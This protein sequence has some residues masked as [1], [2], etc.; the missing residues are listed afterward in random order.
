MLPTWGGKKK[1]KR[2]KKVLFVDRSGVV[3]SVLKLLLQVCVE[4]REGF[5]KVLCFIFLL[6]HHV[7]VFFT[8]SD[9]GCVTLFTLVITIKESLA[10]GNA[11]LLS[12][13][14]CHVLCVDFHR[15]FT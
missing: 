10:G 13:C 14:T 2:K 1:E 7:F 11:K 12:L 5:K 15:P 8:Q 4:G 6:L 9:G 3:N